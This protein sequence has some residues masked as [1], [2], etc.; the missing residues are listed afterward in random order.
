MA[1]IEMTC[2]KPLTSDLA[3]VLLTTRGCAFPAV[4]MHEEFDSKNLAYFYVECF[5]VCPF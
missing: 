4:W 5:F 1:D 3:A 2:E